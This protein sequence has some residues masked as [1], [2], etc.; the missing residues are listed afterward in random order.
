MKKT[1]MT[2]TGRFAPSVIFLLALTGLLLSEPAATQSR[3]GQQFTEQGGEAL[4]KAICQGCH[5][6]DAK[7]AKGAGAY[8]AL[9]GDPALTARAYPVFMVVSGRKAMPAFGGNLTDQQIADVVNYLRSHFGNQYTDQVT[10]SEVR[11]IRNP[12]PPQS[13][14]AQPP[15]R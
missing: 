11:A 1:P 15:T 4:Y 2:P 9:A 14:A 5:M 10:A 3:S 7:G 8:P 12:A 6:P 13:S